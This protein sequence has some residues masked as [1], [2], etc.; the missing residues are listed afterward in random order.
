MTELA[1]LVAQA[2][3]LEVRILTLASLTPRFLTSPDVKHRFSPVLFDCSRYF[4]DAAAAEARIESSRHLQSLDE[5]MREG[6]GTFLAKLWDLYT[7]VLQLQQQVLSH[8]NSTTQASQQ[9]QGPNSLPLVA[10]L[11]SV[12]LLLDTCIPSVARERSIVAHVRLNSGSQLVSHQAAAI[13]RLFAATGFDPDSNKA[14][15]NNIWGAASFPSR[16]FRS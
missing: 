8:I 9:M 15:Q 2:H 3:R 16:L 7:R 14:T 10:L 5:E 13:V 12:L 4:T 6:Y 1:Q 11:G